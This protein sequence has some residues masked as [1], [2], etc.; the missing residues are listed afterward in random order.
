LEAPDHRVLELRVDL[1]VAA[2]L[3]VAAETKLQV[4]VQLT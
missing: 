1:T 2:V 3:V 4:A